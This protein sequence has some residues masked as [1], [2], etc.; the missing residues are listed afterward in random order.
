M[1]GPVALSRRHDAVS[2]TRDREE[3]PVSRKGPAPEVSWQCLRRRPGRHSGVL[4]GPAVRLRS[5]A[6]SR[7]AKRFKQ[8][9]QTHCSDEFPSIAFP[10][11]AGDLVVAGAGSGANRA[12]R[13]TR[14]A[15]SR[16]A[17]RRRRPRR[18]PEDV[19]CVLRPKQIPVRV[20]PSPGSIVCSSALSM[21]WNTWR[22][23]SA[24]HVGVLASNNP[25][26][27]GRPPRSLSTTTRRGSG[28][29]S[30]V[31]RSWYRRLGCDT[32]PAR[33]PASL[34]APRSLPI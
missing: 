29:G 25:D 22:I 28:P 17:P 31:W 11:A 14:R 18:T 20:A 7:A 15:A 8:A 33:A 34:E 9:P 5:P 27:P 21:P 13:H 26:R 23:L 12:W 16:W 30:T 10:L 2:R 4:P 6:R 19:R 24:A 32:A 1:Q 3:G